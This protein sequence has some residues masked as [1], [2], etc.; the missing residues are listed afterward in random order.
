M[1]FSEMQYVR[2]DLNS[3]QRQAKEI[4][5]KITQAN[6]AQEQINAFVAYNRM[7]GNIST[8]K[9]LVHIRSETNTEDPFYNAEREFF[10]QSNPILDQ[11]EQQI[12]QAL[13]GSRFRAELETTFGKVLFT[14]YDIAANTNSAKIT[15][16]IQE[17]N[18]LI[19]AYQ[20][21]NASAVVKFQGEPIPLQKL[22]FF[23]QSTNRS[24]RRA[25]YEAEGQ[26][27]NAHQEEYDQIYDDLVQNRTSQA[28]FLGHKNYLQLGYDRMGRNCYRQEELTAF[29]AQI[30]DDV[31][32]RI[33][34]IK[35]AQAKR[36]GVDSLKLHD[37]A[38]LFPDGNAAPVGT[39]EDIIEAGK[40][41]YTDFSPETAAYAEVL[42]GNGMIDAIPRKGKVSGGYCV[43]IYNHKSTFILA[44]FN[45]TSADADVLIHEGGHGFAFYR[46]MVQ[47][48]RP[49]Q[50][51]VPTADGRETHAMTMEFLLSDYYPLFFGKNARKYE[52]G[53]CEA[54]FTH[55]PYIC[56]VDEFQ[57]VMYKQ[58]RLTPAERNQVW[59][60][61]EK[62]YRPWS[63]FDQLPFY[64]R[65]AGWQRQLHIYQ[66]PLFY[67]EYGLA[68][69]VAFQ[70]WN[71]YRKD[72]QDAW[73]RYLTFVD[74]G[75]TE[76]FQDL[77]N[78]AG[79]KLP[80]EPGC[81]KEV[82]D[83]VTAWLRAHSDLS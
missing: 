10:N 75:G 69:V 15:E 24:T 9:A 66:H 35:D 6:S 65:G 31:V 42:F 36:L 16:L 64:S 14:N 51:L 83:A 21:L 11:I 19:R 37:D 20:S 18:R 61:L 52:I 76:S 29:R 55:I 8:M 78:Q 62:K 59:L 47:K 54:S 33:K 49:P 25:A 82:S 5:Q 1:N 56:Q 58:P 81:L 73:E 28:R 32:P 77:V 71:L 26:F 79:L 2:P 50:L 7:Y 45:G 38:L 63:D 22:G 40:K 30:V 80:Y 68:Q 13:S 39:L 74:K 23:K 53:H 48:N 44:N 27:Y 12:G 57:H 41:A 43:E 67:I 72:K 34:Q 46:S 17:E 60:E 4:V 3:I 70:F